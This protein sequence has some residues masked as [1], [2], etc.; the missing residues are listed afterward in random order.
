METVCLTEHNSPLAYKSLYNEYLFDK[1]AQEQTLQRMISRELIMT[2]STTLKTKERKLSMLYESK[3]GDTIK[4]KWNKFIDFINNLFAKFGESISNIALSYKNYLV[5]YRDIILNKAFKIKLTQALPGDYN[6]GVDRCNKV[7]IPVFQY[8]DQN[9]KT[10]LSEDDEQ[11]IKMIIKDSE[12]EYDQAKNLNDILK[13]YFLGIDKGIV[14]NLDNLNRSDMYNFC[15]NA[16][17]IQ[18]TRKKDMNAL[19]STTSVIERAITNEVNKVNKEAYIMELGFKKND[20][21]QP[22]PN[23][24]ATAS[25]QS[26]DQNNNQNNTATTSGQST[27]HNNNN[28]NK[29]AGKDNVAKAGSVNTSPINSSLDDN[30]KGT[31][32]E[33][34]Y[35]QDGQQAANDGQDAGDIAKAFDAWR[36]VC[37]AVISAKMT[38]QQAILKDYMGII[39]AHVRSYVGKQDNPE[40]NQSAGKPTNYA[41]NNNQQN[42]DNNK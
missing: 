37:Q 26:T 42:N 28:Q 2:E 40:D 41:K 29:E 33:D 20:S 15:L 24:T 16:D 30:Y 3:M 13:D 35:K 18:S 14:D 8:S 23:S 10:L 38:A 17:K 5:K 12:L 9:M 39:R 27:D 22:E 11:I 4:S 21:S 7:V 25:G 36:K 19:K 34:D 31:T 6:T 32:K 1:I